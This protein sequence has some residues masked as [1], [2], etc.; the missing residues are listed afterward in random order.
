MGEE[1]LGTF[2]SLGDGTMTS[3]R[4]EPVTFPLEAPV[5][6]GHAGNTPE[7]DGRATQ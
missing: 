7:D 1:P 2:R 6:I 3:V 5:R 4:D